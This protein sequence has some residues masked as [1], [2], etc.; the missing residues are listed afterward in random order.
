MS[1]TVTSTEKTKESGSTHE[2]KALLY[3]MNCRKDSDDIFFFVIDFFNDLTGVDRAGSK[4]WDMQSKSTKNLTA[5]PLGRDLVTLYKNYLSEFSFNAYILFVG[6]ISDSLMIDKSA[7][8]FTIDN[9]TLTAQKDILLYLKAESKDK[10]Y[11]PDEMIIDEKMR[12][13]LSKVIFVIDREKKSDY[14]RK[15]VKVNPAILPSDEY[16]DRIFDQIRS[17]QNDKKNLNTEN[18]T[19][20]SLIEFEKYRKH[21]T[22]HEVKMMVLNR[23]IHKNGINHTPIS[24]FSIL[25]GRDAPSKKEVLEDCQN[26]M[27]RILCDVNNGPAYWELFEEIYVLVSNNP[28][29]SV[30]EIYTRLDKSKVNKIQFLNFISTKFFIALIKDGLQQ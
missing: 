12:D 21:L 28:L 1:Y 10:T 26:S 17:A 24:F 18:V 8:S 23:L 3:L 11:I 19:I 20:N 14:I 27:F 2:T 25:E 22:N 7:S 15:I 29:E 5:S 30:D 4:A 13:F 9:F 6:G 16:L